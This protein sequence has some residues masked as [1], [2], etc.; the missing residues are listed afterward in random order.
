MKLQVK[1]M[2][3]NVLEFNGSKSTMNS[4][5]LDLVNNHENGKYTIYDIS[6][7]IQGSINERKLRYFSFVLQQTKHKEKFMLFETE[8]SVLVAFVKLP[9]NSKAAKRIKAQWRLKK[10]T[11]RVS[12]L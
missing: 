11:I 7:P 2:F 12:Y 1:D 4:D 8:G 5:E 3:G 9:N 6:S 10:H